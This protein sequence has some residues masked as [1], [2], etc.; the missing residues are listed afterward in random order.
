MYETTQVELN[1]TSYE[2]LI[3]WTF[4]VHVSVHC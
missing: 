2:I 1:E 3:K 4:K